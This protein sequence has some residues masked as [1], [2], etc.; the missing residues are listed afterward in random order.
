MLRQVSE[1]QKY[2]GAPILGLKHLVFVTKE[3]ASQGTIGKIK[4]FVGGLLKKKG[5]D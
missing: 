5:K 3:D 1:F 4:S 2:G